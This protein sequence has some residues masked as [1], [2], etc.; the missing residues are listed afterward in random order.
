MAKSYVRNCAEYLKV[1]FAKPEDVEDS[2]SE[3]MNKIIKED[4]IKPCDEYIIEYDRIVTEDGK[5]F[6]NSKVKRSRIAYSLRPDVLDTMHNYAKQKTTRDTFQAMEAFV[7]NMCTLASRAGSQVPFSSVNMGLDVTW[8][9]RMVTKSLLDAVYAGLGNGET[10]IFPISIFKMKK[11]VNDKGSPNYDLFKLAC[12]VSALRLFP[13]FIN[14]DSSFNLPYYKENQPE[15]H[16]AVMGMTRDGGITIKYK[17]AQTG[18]DISM[19]EDWIKTNPDLKEKESIQFDEHTS[20]YNLEDVDIY[21]R[22]DFADKFVKLNKWM[23]SSDPNATWYKVTFD[24]ES[25]LYLTSDHPL[26]VLNLRT[27]IW[28][29]TFV[30]QIKEND[31][32]YG[33]N[34]IHRVV[35]SIEHLD[36][37][38][39]G[40]DVETASDRFTLGKIVSH[41]CRT[42][43]LGNVHDPDKAITPGRGNLFPITINLPYIA[44]EAKEAM[45][46]ASQDELIKEFYRR[47]DERQNEVFDILLERFEMVAKRKAYNYPFMMGQHIYLDSEQ[48]NPDSEI[49]EVIKHGTLTTGFIGLAET[50]V[51]LTGKHHGES[52]ESWKIGYDIISHLN[53]LNNA[54]SMLTKLN[55]TLMGSPAEGC[56]GRLLRCTRD[57]FG[58]IPG[59]TD[60]EYLVNSCHIP[61]YYKISVWD[62]IKKEGP[63]HKLC[64][65]G[66]IFYAE[67]D[68]DISNNIDVFEKM[69]N[70]MAEAD[71]GYYAINH[72]VDR[73]PVCG[74]VGIIGDTCPR[75]GRKDGEGVEAYKLMEL[76]SYNPDPAYAVKASMIE[77]EDETL[78]ND[79]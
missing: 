40:Y 31:L 34:L 68:Q 32:V 71:M 15:T 1:I 55:F 58:V 48:L 13:T 77:E 52:D 23:H 4:L 16:I 65:A 41:N 10:A 2:L 57:R 38:F 59:V 79:I 25:V 45:P 7:H 60:H 3:N 46:N 64:P 50:L 61:V 63:F 39:V 73:D 8:E 12:K 36:E 6:I 30:H 28:E 14:V 78:T 53:D 11:G 76:L 35:K 47:L 33:M 75:C 22:D 37:T 74:Y 42:R 49:R 56:C 62:K 20:Y 70:A 72:P 43:V 29:R 26:P 69:V 27:K 44:L 5:K 21:I 24:D 51:V 9:G 17:G 18:L 19:M 67:V 54:K 66:I